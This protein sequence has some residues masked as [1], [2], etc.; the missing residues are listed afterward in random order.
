MD[1]SQE[2]RDSYHYKLYIYY[3]S[4]AVPVYVGAVRNFHAF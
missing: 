2:N 3:R 1:T 4:V